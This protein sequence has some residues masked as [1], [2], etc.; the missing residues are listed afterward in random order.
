M[1]EMVIIKKI[2]WQ[3]K[4]VMSFVR[5]IKHDWGQA[6]TSTIDSQVPG[7]S[8]NHS[9]FLLDLLQKCKAVDLMA[10]LMGRLRG[11][12]PDLII[13]CRCHTCETKWVYWIGLF[14]LCT[15][16]VVTASSS[17][18]KSW[19]LDRQWSV[20]CSVA[21]ADSNTYLQT[22]LAIKKMTV[23]P[24]CISQFKSSYSH[25]FLK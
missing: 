11:R 25:I 6:G 18:G 8:M 1:M 9:R 5:T 10:L 12:C 14:K 21:M 16:P 17:V 15:L 2:H 3:S 7:L 19:I 20:W 22:P 24:I 23:A 4:M 13:Q